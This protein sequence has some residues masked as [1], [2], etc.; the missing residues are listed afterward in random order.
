MNA[1]YLLGDTVTGLARRPTAF[2]TAMPPFGEQHRACGREI[3]RLN[4]ENVRLA[5][6]LA[7]ER[8]RNEGIGDQV[9][10]RRT[11]RARVVGHAKGVTAY[12][13]PHVAPVL[14][15]GWAP[16]EPQDE[17]SVLRECDASPES[18][19]LRLRSLWDATGEYRVYCLESDAW[20]GVCAATLFTAETG[21]AD[22]PAGAERNTRL[23]AV[24]HTPDE[25]A[26]IAVDFFNWDIESDGGRW[27][28]TLAPAP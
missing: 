26:R 15:P 18:C 23:L 6:Q 13:E 4:N 8:A 28:L 24:A 2:G 1:K 12:P 19:R 22:G 27:R 5:D 10:L 7:N 21:E 9:R 20:R 3:L 14:P 25:A 16:L 11:R 17:S